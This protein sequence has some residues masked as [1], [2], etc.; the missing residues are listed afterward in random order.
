MAN[1]P[2]TPPSPR[3]RVPEFLRPEKQPRAIKIA[4]ILAFL[5]VVA[6][7]TWRVNR[8][9]N[10]PPDYLPHTQG[11][12]DFH[13][14]VY[15]PALAYRQGQ[16]PYSE[17]YAREY[18]IGRQLPLYSPGMFWLHYPFAV[19]PLPIANVVYYLVSLGLV[20]ALAYSALAV[21]RLP[22]SVTNV[23]GL[24][25]LILLSRPGH[26]NLLLGQMT[27]PIVIGA[28]WSIELAR[29]RPWLAGLAFALT[30]V[31]PTFAVP[32]IWL[33]FCR[34]DY[35]AV[36][37]SVLIGGGLAIAAL[38]PIV[39]RD[40]LPAVIESLK[41]S[42]SL[43]E[44][45]PVVAAETTWTR[46]D[47][48]ALVGKLSPLKIA[49]AFDLLITAACLLAAGAAVFRISTLPQANGADSLSAL[50]IA[51]ATLACIYHSSYDALLLVVPWIG[52]AFGRLRD[53]LPS[54]LL[55]VVWFLLTIPALNYLSARSVTN[56]LGVT[57]PLWTAITALNSICILVTLILAISIAL[58]PRQTAAV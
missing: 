42:Q 56:A 5:A 45:D 48:P 25:T 23:L 41:K 13:N 38:A 20:L 30:T 17:A 29:K 18:P 1:P 19:L 21:C 26:I 14:G 44:N 36:V 4:V 12:A 55:P 53:H 35:R 46:I 10:R 58:S 31:K 15:Y 28:I 37:W 9:L 40:G 54:R 3:A 11:L 43:H 47:T 8:T 32:I 34:R 16:N 51:A 49:P 39:A 2:T 52:A 24:A 7:S 50:I 27:L 57:G 6:L 33:M 22:C